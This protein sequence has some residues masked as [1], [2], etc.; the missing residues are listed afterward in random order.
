MVYKCRDCKREVSFDANKHPHP[1]VVSTGKQAFD[2]EGNPYKLCCY[3]KGYI[4][5]LPDKPERF[6]RNQ[7]EFER[8]VRGGMYGS[9]AQH[10]QARFDMT[11]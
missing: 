9:L 11:N 8:D 6:R 10:T 5:S 4:D 2:C 1:H 3:P 7:S